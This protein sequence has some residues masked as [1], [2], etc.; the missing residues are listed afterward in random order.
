MG[1]VFQEQPT[2]GITEWLLAHSQESK[3]L[4]MYIT[5]MSN[6]ITQERKY[7]CQLTGFDPQ[8]IHVPFY[9]TQQQHLWQTCL[10]WPVAL[11]AFAGILD[12]HP[13]AHKLLQLIPL[14]PFVWPRVTKATPTPGAPTYFT[15]GSN[16][17]KAGIARPEEW[18]TPVTPHTSA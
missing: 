15:E 3:T 8:T 18:E 12:S 1:V 9:K 10:P 7:T 11:T 17:G 6:L 14:T 5:L 2:F 13:P 4:M 16:N